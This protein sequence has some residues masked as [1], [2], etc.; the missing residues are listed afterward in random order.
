MEALGTFVLNAKC[1][2][3]C[4]IIGKFSP[5]LCLLHSV[6]LRKWLEQDS[7]YKCVILIYSAYHSFVANFTISY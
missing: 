1:A 3:E 4:N 6:I 5:W 7:I 2:V